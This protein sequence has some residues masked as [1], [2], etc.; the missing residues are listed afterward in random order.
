MS[1]YLNEIGKKAKEASYIT[2]VLSTEEKNRGLSA[3]SK[4]LA[5]RSSE[6]I[7]ANKIDIDNGVSKGMTKALLDRLSLDEKRIAGISE[8]IDQVVAL[9][10]PVGKKLEEHQHAKGMLISKVAVPLGVTAIIY[11]ARP[12]VTADAFALCFKTG[13]SVVLRGGSDAINSNKAI[14]K[15]IRETLEEEKLPE[16]SIQLL[17]D[18]SRETATELMRLKEYI[19]VLI[20]R[21]SAKL[22][23][24][25]VE[26]S[27]VPV[28]ETG[29]GNCHVYVDES[30]N[31]DMAVNIIFNAKTQRFGV[32]NACESLLL[33]ESIYKD[34]MPKI[35][36]KLAEKDVEIHADEKI[37]A[38]IPDAILATEE[39]W[40]TEYLGPTISAKV[41]SSVDEAIT[42]INKYNT[43]HS[44]TIV[45]ENKENA[46]KFL[47]R[48]DAAAVYHN[49]STRFTDGFEF[50]MGAEIGIST[51]KLHAR[52]PMGLN[53]LTSYKY[54][55]TG[56][57]QIR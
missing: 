2:A 35:A 53:E 4:A 14:V 29:S 31:I 33:H 16:D 10:D 45:T 15:I 20:P 25:C 30:A 28:I 1:D 50:G 32:C 37:C 44:E 12:N 55:I 24:S 8:G 39:D 36:A 3:V 38:V 51:Q 56:D 52:G 34:A 43:K 23:K 5:N 40:G 48:V 9:E 6:I 11:E 54:Q 46:E 18:T 57:G 22:I 42:H 26:N 7:E 41:V 19:D 13:N 17:E 27:T 49:V 47:Q 21:G